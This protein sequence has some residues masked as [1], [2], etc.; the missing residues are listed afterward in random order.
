MKL[1]ILNLDNV[2]LEEQTNKVSE[3]YQ[4][5]IGAKTKEERI[6]EGLDLMQTIMGAILKEVDIDGLEV[7]ADAHYGKL[8]RRCWDFD[9]E[10]NLE[11]SFK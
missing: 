2:T 8:I 5:F 4:E 7:F 6:L 11:F 1:P 9:G 10:V 3:E